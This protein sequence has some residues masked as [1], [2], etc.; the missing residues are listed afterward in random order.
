MSDIPAFAY[1]LLWGERELCS[2]A[3][4]TREDGRDFFEQLPGWEIRT[5]ITPYPLDD[6]NKALHDLKTGKLTGAAVLVPGT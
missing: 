3:N 2:V 6:A 4:L 5:Q 1:D